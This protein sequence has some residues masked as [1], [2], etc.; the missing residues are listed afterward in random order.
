[1]SNQ[2]EVAQLLSLNN[3]KNV[4]HVD[5]Q[6]NVLGEE[7]RAIPD[8]GE[9]GRKNPA[10]DKNISDTMPAPASVPRPIHQDEGAG[11][12]GGPRGSDIADPGHC[13]PPIAA[14]NAFRKPRLVIIKPS[15]CSVAAQAVSVP[16]LGSVC[17]ASNPAS[18][19]R[20]VPEILII[21]F[22]LQVLL[23]VPC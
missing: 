20:L 15:L 9:S 12:I 10:S 7:M 19:A 2:N 22:S 14:L 16:R 13:T 5:L 17:L 23:F 8:S 21:K 1:M 11:R 6:R 18:Y 3:G 4:F